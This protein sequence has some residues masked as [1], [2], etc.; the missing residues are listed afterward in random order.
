M[1]MLY[2]IA[3]IISTNVCLTVRVIYSLI[4]LTTATSCRPRVLR[5]HWSLIPTEERWKG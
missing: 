1:D 3:Y 4:W 2:Y 5:L